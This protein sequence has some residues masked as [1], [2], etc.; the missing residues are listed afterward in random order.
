MDYVVM[1]KVV[2]KLIQIADKAETGFWIG[3]FPGFEAYIDV[4][5]GSMYY[6]EFDEEGI[7]NGIITSVLFD[8]K[9]IDDG[10]YWNSCKGT[11]FH[12]GY[13]KNGE[14]S[15]M[16]SCYDK[17]GCLVYHGLFADDKPTGEYPM[18]I[19]TRM[20]FEAIE[21]SNGDMYI[22]QRK[23]CRHG[24]GIYIWKDG[25][26][27][28]AKWGDGGKPERDGVFITSTGDITNPPI[29]LEFASDGR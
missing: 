24:F 8:S 11:L 7:P 6:G 26:C 9:K 23:E 19:D 21:Y 20:R 13:W 16:G 14:V 17:N 18:A 5:D 2:N 22:G 27:L 3:S 10:E 1:S 15:G 12:V 29:I 25:S 4:E 28:Y